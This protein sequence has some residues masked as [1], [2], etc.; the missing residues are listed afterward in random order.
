M[1]ILRAKNTLV[2]SIGSLQLDGTY[3]LPAWGWSSKWTAGPPVTAG[4]H[5]LTSPSPPPP[6]YS[7]ALQSTRPPDTEQNRRRQHSP[8]KVPGSEVTLGEC[9]AR[10]LTG[11]RER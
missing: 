5:H 1:D 9:M 10:G 2:P 8:R 6:V 4:P 7:E 11:R 3:H